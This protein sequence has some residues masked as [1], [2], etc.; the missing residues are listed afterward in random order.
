[1]AS[2][3]TDTTSEELTNPSGS[4]MPT[5]LKYPTMMTRHV[6]FAEVLEHSSAAGKKAE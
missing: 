6:E 2:L 1:M 3:V 5:R 4:E